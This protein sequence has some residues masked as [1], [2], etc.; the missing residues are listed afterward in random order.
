MGRNGRV[1]IGQLP[2][3]TEVPEARNY[4]EFV[5]EAQVRM[6]IARGSLTS[7]R[8]WYELVAARMEVP[9]TQTRNGALSITALVAA[10]QG[11]W[12]QAMRLSERVTGQAFTLGIGH[13]SSRLAYVTLISSALA[14]SDFT[15]R[16][17]VELRSRSGR[18]AGARRRSAR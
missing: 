3:W 15:W 17:R 1:W 4:C 8:R 7:A 6:A 5:T 11:D 13:P 12:S 18:V 2:D 10:A 14:R 9:D 16:R